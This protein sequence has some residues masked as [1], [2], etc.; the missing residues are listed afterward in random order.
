MYN[1]ISCICIDVLNGGEFWLLCWFKFRFDHYC[2][3]FELAV[4]RLHTGV[5]LC[6]KSR[7]RYHSGSFAVNPFNEFLAALTGKFSE[8]LKLVMLVDGSLGLFAFIA[9][10]A[11]AHKINEPIFIPGFNIYVPSI[12][13]SSS[14]AGLLVSSVVSI[15]YVLV[16]I[17]LHSKTSWRIAIF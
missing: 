3:C 15:F 2:G 13:S 10:I 6:P 5:P 11:V 14:D 7:A 16:F 17:L 12:V 8:N 9:G 4:H 1:G